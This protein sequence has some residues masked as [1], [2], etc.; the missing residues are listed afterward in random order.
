MPTTARPTSGRCRCPPLV[1]GFGVPSSLAGRCRLRPTSCCSPT[2][3][4]TSAP[5]PPPAAEVAGLRLLQRRPRQPRPAARP[6]PAQRRGV[7]E[8]QGRAPTSRCSPASASRRT[9]WCRRISRKA[10]SPRSSPAA[11]TPVQG[12]V[13][14]SGRLLVPEAK[15]TLNYGFGKDRSP[16]ARPLR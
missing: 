2:A 3:W 8:P 13:T 1:H 10:R 16:T 7:L 4:A 15:V 14:V 6:L 5:K 9:R 12:R 11:G